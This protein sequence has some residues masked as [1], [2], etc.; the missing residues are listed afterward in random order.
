VYNLLPKSGDLFSDRIRI[1]FGRRPKGAQAQTLT[2]D[3]KVALKERARATFHLTMVA[4][5]TLVGPLTLNLP[6]ALHLYWLSS[7]ATNA[8]FVK[9]IKH[10]MP[11]KGK[12]QKRCT[13]VELPVIRPRRDQL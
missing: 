13:G 9:I 2:G 10:L 6:A 4:L 5:A 12:L 1:A 11:V 7:S 8:L 3:E